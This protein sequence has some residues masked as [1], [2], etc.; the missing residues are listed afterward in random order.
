MDQDV[1]G[2]NVNQSKPTDGV[3]PLVIV[4]YTTINEH[5]P[6]YPH[7]SETHEIPE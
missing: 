5:N 2:G 4:G 3:N 6:D 1:S 7:S